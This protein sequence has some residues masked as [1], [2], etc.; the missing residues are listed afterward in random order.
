MI[1]GGSLMT[2]TFPDTWGKACA[3]NVQGVRCRLVGY[4][5]LLSSLPLIMPEFTLSHAHSKHNILV[6]TLNLA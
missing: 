1:T 3:S 5:D 2:N 4:H 6:C